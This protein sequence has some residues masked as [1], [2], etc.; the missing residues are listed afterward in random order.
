MEN[1]TASPA[2]DENSKGSSAGEDKP[3]PP[4]SPADFRVY[5]SLAERMDAFVSPL[6]RPEFVSIWEFKKS[7]I[8]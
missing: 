6:S 7:P 4:L 3:L 2:A 5:N 1:S 8:N